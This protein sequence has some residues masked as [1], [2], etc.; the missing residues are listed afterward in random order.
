MGVSSAVFPLQR[1]I[2]CCSLPRRE[3]LES[4]ATEVQ[5]RRGIYYCSN[6]TL[7][8]KVI[9]FNLDRFGITWN[10]DDGVQACGMPP[11]QLV[12]AFH[13]FSIF[14]HSKKRAQSS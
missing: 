12:Y 3:C 4:R 14:I 2:H 9:M 10:S 13:I 6:W 5:G 1:L 11:R 8:A 7:D